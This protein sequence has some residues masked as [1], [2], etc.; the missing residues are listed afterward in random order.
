MIQVELSAADVVVEPGG[1]AQLS[2]TI[3]NRQEVAETVALE[4][5]GLDV[6]WYALPVPTFHLA[7]GQ[8]QTAR[9]LF[10]VPRSSH[11][12]A[13]AYPFVVRA[14]GMES[15]VSGLQQ[16]VLTVKPYSSLQV[17]MNPRRA[18][19][20]F[21]NRTAV[22]DVTIA[23]LGN[24]ETNLDLYAA[25]PEDSCAYEFD[26]S[27]VTLKP[28]HNQTVPLVAEPVTRPVLGSPR[29]IGFTV[30]ARSVEDSYLSANSSG[31]IERRPLL[32]TV[33]AV[34][35]LLL[36]TLA[37]GFAMFR[38][39]PAVVR[40]F[41]ASPMQVVAGETVT[42]AWDAANIGDGSHILPGNIRLG[43]SVG[44]VQVQPQETTTY[45]LIVRSGSQEITREVTVVVTPR[46]PSPKPEI[47]SF[48][49]TRTR[50]HP[51]DPVTLSWKLNG[52]KQIVL[53]PFGTPREYPLF[54]SQEVKPEQ[55]T[56]YELSAKG[57]GGEIVSKSITVVVEPVN[58]PI[59]EIRGF[60]AKPPSIAP[61][62]KTTLAWQVEGADVVEIDN[63][64][65]ANLGAKGKVEVSPMTTTT[66][67][68]RALDNKGNSVTKTLTVTVKDPTSPQDPASQPG[69]R[70]TT[71]P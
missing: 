6:E 27:R 26:T 64:V 19:T 18:V 1:T 10:K 49:A 14:R 13:G 48:T 52:A 33:T 12:E 39:R 41:T 40:S 28:G 47:L 66:Y 3:S 23:N 45:R 62:A 63:G 8:T 65:G 67:T 38:P 21:F 37:A 61:G 5:E 54:T 42:L 17:E 71:T 44:T 2:I 59:A 32:S 24:H 11:A 16:A 60:N 53:N 7:V 55:T 56:T 22:F 70:P 51:G 20:G 50:V 15:G 43:G 29:L 57:E 58:V 68:L 31:Q 30:T 46:P 9:V 4:I 35:V 69:E 36:F 25:D 34:A